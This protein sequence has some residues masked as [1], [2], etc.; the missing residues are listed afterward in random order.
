MSIENLFHKAYTGEAKAALR[1][2]LFAEK[3]DEE[4]YT[5][6]GRLFRVIS[7]SEEIHGARSLKMLDT[8]KS[9]EEN[10]QASFESE[11]QIAEVSYNEFLKEAEK[12]GNSAASKIFS[13]S[14]D[15]EEIHAKLYKK[16]LGHMY[17]ESETTYY[18][19]KVC[20]Y[21]SDTI[22][23]DKCPVCNASSKNFIE[24]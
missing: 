11:T 5:Q 16:A 4:G 21:I 1:L 20:G 14:R 18:I 17:E 24:Y 22:L 6:M 3:A 2:K 9:T 15:V 19:C 10:L 7:L 23:P 8:V 12:E 13:Q